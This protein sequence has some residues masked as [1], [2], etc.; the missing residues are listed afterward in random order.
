MAHELGDAVRL[1]AP[2]GRI[3]HDD[4][5]VTVHAD[6][7]ELRA[8]RC[9][10]ALPPAL[11]GRL[12]YAPALPGY[13]DQLAQRVPMGTVLK[14]FAI[15]DEPFWRHAGMTGQAVSDRG[16]VKVTFDNSP[17]D[18]TPG[19]L[20][21]FAEG[22]AGRRIGLLDPAERRRKV[23]ECFPRYFGRR[24]AR[25]SAFV[26]QSWAEEEHTRGCYAGYFPPGVWTSYG[27][28][29]RRPVGRLHW[30]GTETA[31]VF[32]GYIEGAVRSGERA[33]RELLD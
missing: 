8:G 33:A 16:P 3:G 5:G 2:V 26:E 18:G 1:G 19:V 12:R 29:L 27:P 14:F 28:A 10:V 11:A 32:C 9:I 30:A 23:L 20:L 21:G 24:A 25:P 15:Y 22:D 6:R 31:S 4:E 17:S 13:R 7:H